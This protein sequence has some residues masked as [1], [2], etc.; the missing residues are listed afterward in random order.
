MLFIKV[1]PVRQHSNPQSLPLRRSFFNRIPQRYRILIP[2][3]DASLRQSINQFTLGC[4]SRLE[5]PKAFTVRCIEAGQNPDCRPHQD[6]KFFDVAAAV[7]AHLYNQ[8]IP[9]AEISPA[10]PLGNPKQGVDVFRGFMHAEFLA[11]DLGENFFSGGLA[12]TAGNT[13][14]CAER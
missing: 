14:D 6:T 9:I 8:N 10:Y 11:E 1:A 12:E 13:D 7:G 3:T 2:K 5:R 4:H